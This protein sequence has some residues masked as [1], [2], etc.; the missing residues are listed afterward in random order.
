MKTAIRGQNQTNWLNH[1]STSPRL[2]SDV[3]Q[4]APRKMRVNK[5]GSLYFAT[6]SQ[7]YSDSARPCL[8]TGTISPSL[9]QSIDIDM[10]TL[11]TAT[12]KEAEQ[13]PKMA[14]LNSRKPERRAHSQR[15]HD[16]FPP[17][18][19]CSKSNQSVWNS[20]VLLLSQTGY[21]RILPEKWHALAIQI[22]KCLRCFLL[23]SWVIS[24]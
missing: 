13:L 14:S 10:D 8:S 2:V 4:N 22:G 23:D 9:Y 16:T 21:G 6:T 19:Q 3:E 15:T 18:R 24:S 20:N 7:V 17:I 11:C 1:K 12:T 5:I